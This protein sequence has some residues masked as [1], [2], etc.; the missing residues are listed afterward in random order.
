MPIRV[1]EL[2]IALNQHIPPH[3]QGSPNNIKFTELDIPRASTAYDRLR[4]VP[5][6]YI[7]LRSTIAS[8]GEYGPKGNCGISQQRPHFY[9]SSRLSFPPFLGCRTPLI[10]IM[11]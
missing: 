4:T 2:F 3:S 7:G 8:D 11:R 1:C 5:G 6:G 10:A 9:V